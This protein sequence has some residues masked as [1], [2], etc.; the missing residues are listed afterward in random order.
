MDKKISFNLTDTSKTSTWNLST[1]T[2][3]DT[4]REDGD[5]KKPR[6]KKDASIKNENNLFSN[7]P[8]EYHEWL[9]FFKKDAIT[10]SQ[11]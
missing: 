11:Y 7:I 2:L 6:G 4:P 3:V 10:L 8:K 1:A 5:Y 9:H